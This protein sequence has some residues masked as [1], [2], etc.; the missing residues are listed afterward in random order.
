VDQPGAESD[1]AERRDPARA[2]DGRRRQRGG[3]PEQERKRIVCLH[4]VHL[5]D[6]E[7]ARAEGDRAE[8]QQRL[9]DGRAGAAREP[10]QVA[11]AVCGGDRGEQRGHA[12]GARDRV[13]VGREEEDDPEAGDDRADVGQCLHHEP[14]ALAAR[15]VLLVAADR[16]RLLL[17]DQPRFDPGA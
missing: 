10:E 2:H 12:S 16:V 8:Q 11:E 7:E 14:S 6:E 1:Q 17:G 4:V 9:A 5:A 13:P 3:R 15:G